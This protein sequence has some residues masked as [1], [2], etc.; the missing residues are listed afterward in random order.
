MAK[1]KRENNDKQNERKRK[2]GRG[3]G[4]LENYKPWLKTQDLGSE[5]LATRI[6]GVKT[7]RIHQLLSTLELVLRHSNIDG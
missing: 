3:E 7:G 4:I 1:R 6:K 2:E 5:G